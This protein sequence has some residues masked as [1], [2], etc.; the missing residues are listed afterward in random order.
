LRG[1]FGKTIWASS[2]SMFV[3]GFLTDIGDVSADTGAQ[4][5]IEQINGTI[6]GNVSATRC[7]TIAL[8]DRNIL[9]Q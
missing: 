6:R 5:N 9:G 7:A 3:G 2:G 4:I 8:P 1:I